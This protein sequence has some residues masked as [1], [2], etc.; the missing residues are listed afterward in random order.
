MLFYR[1]NY[2]A[3]VGVAKVIRICGAPRRN[4]ICRPAYKSGNRAANRLAM[5]HIGRATQK[6]TQNITKNRKITRRL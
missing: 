6:K 5:L 4:A 3:S 2:Q 1:P